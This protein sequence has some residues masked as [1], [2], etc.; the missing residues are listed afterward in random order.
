MKNLILKLAAAA[1]LALALACGGSKNNSTTAVTGVTLP[2][3]LTV[4]V[5]GQAELRATILPDNASNKKVSW[6]SSNPDA[7]TVPN[8]DTATINV[9]GRAAGTSEI[10]VTTAD[11]AKTAAC[12]VTAVNPVLPTSVAIT[13]KPVSIDIGGSATLTATILPAD[14]TNKG[15]TWSISPTTFATLSGSGLTATVTGTAAG[16][17]TVTVTTAAGSRTDTCQVTVTPPVVH[18]TSVTIS[19]KPVSLV[20]TGGTTTATLTATVLPEGAANKSVTWSISPAGVATLTPNGSS[21]TLTAAGAGSATVTVTTA[22]GGKT[23]TCAV[24]V[25]GPV[26]VTNVTL[27]GTLTVA[28]NR[29]ASLTATIEP[30]GAT[31]KN[32][33]WTS[34]DPTKA[35]VPSGAQSNIITVTGVAQGTT[36]ITV[37][38]A[39][40]TNGTKTAQCVVTVGPAATGPEVYIG[41]DFGMIKDGAVQAAYNGSTVLAIEV[42]GSNV[43]HAC[44]FTGTDASYWRNGTRQ[45]LPKTAGLEAAATGLCIDGGT[46]YIS[47]YE[48]NSSRAFVKHWTVSSTGTVAN[49]AVAAVSGE[50]HSAANGVCRLG[51]KTYLAGEIAT[52]SYYF[53]DDSEEEEYPGFA[54]W[55]LSA[56]A[57][58]MVNNEGTVALGFL[59]GIAGS[60]NYL[61]AMG[62]IHGGIVCDISGST[63]QYKQ[64]TSSNTYSNGGGI[65]G[66]VKIIGGNLYS[67]GYYSVSQSNY[68]ACYW[69]GP[70]AGIF[71][72]PATFT[73]TGLP[74][75]S[76]TG[77]RWSEGRDIYYANSTTYT[78]GLDNFKSGTNP[79]EDSP[80]LWTG[81]TRTNIAGWSGDRT[82]GGAYAIF[83]K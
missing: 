26:A 57:V 77:F 37:T 7:V 74:N 39:D 44:G 75:G 17:A 13:P 16:T 4:D 25:T 73:R 22:D 34:S 69:S 30:A 78:C 42:D 68:P 53:Y 72:N 29:T 20:T 65:L 23:D 63:W 31:N 19:P 62:E 10:T 47:G 5:G 6:A 58:R 33:T 36:T 12:Q 60:G 15:V 71:A 32:C 83:V 41:G 38:A 43:V 64:F 18:P 11:G 3:T 55:D 40:T 66:G 48:Q 59:N 51:G 52:S 2:A 61:F 70:A 82:K 24:T 1:T 79:A 76:G 56:N 49:V 54:I 45:T 80:V 28:S 35:T 14:A 50:L 27:P 67:A 81:T 9:T 46:V 8:A 21:A